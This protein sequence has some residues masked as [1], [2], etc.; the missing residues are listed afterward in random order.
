[1]LDLTMSQPSI[2]AFATGHMLTR[3]RLEQDVDNYCEAHRRSEPYASPLLAHDLG[4]L[5]PTLVA[6]AE[7]DLLRDDG[8]RYAQRLASAGVNA[9]AV[10]WAGHLHGSL[11]L[12]RLVVS[13]NDWHARNHAFLRDHHAAQVE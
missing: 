11:G 8:E 6:T 13:A 2:A 10:R 5:P 3:D 9:S 12:T 7:Y 4:G 1:M